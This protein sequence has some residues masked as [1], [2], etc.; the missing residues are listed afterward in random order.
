MF[1]AEN[2]ILDCDYMLHRDV[3]NTH[4]CIFGCIHRKTVT[5][6]VSVKEWWCW[7]SLTPECCSQREEECV[8]TAGTEVPLP[9]G[10]WQR[11]RGSPVF[12]KGLPCIWDGESKLFSRLPSPLAWAFIWAKGPVFKGAAVA[13]ILITPL[14]KHCSPWEVVSVCYTPTLPFLELL[15]D[16]KLF[17]MFLITTLLLVTAS[18]L[19]STCL[20][21]DAFSS[22]RKITIAIIHSGFSVFLL[23]WLLLLFKNM[24]WWMKPALKILVKSLHKSFI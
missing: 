18:S 9:S 13:G 11:L 4:P 7:M 6:T 21:K 17:L 16:P 22:K 14:Y 19:I 8:N 12:L 1:C 10:A 3:Q 20:L 5:D 2:S 24:F 23:L 15:A